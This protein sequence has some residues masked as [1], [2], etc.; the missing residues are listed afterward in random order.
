MKGESELG[1]CH[2]IMCSVSVQDAH[3]PWGWH[4]VVSEPSRM[5]R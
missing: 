5:Q 1:P 3:L 4:Q 2:R